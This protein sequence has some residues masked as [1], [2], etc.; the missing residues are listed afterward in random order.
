MRS[1]W[2]RKIEGSNPSTQ[3]YNIY[4]IIMYQLDLMIAAGEVYMIWVIFVLVLV[5]LLNWLNVVVRLSLLSLVMELFLQVEGFCIKGGVVGNYH[6]LFDRF[7]NL[8]VILILTVLMFIFAVSF[9]YMK[10]EGIKMYEIILLMLVGTV[11][12]LGVLRSYN[13]IILFLCLE[14]YSLCMYVIANI[15][16]VSNF[17]TEAGLKYYILGALSSGFFLYGMSICYSVVGSVGYQD[18][19]L[20][21]ACDMGNLLY[22]GIFFIS[23]SFLLK[24]GLA[25]FHVWV[26]DVYEGVTT[27]VS[28]FFSLVPKVGLLSG[29]V[30]L[31][32]GIF[33]NIHPVC[34]EFIGFIGVSSMLFGTMGALWQSKIKRLLAYS[35][36]VNM[37]YLM[38]PLIILTYSGV[39]SFFLYLIIYEYTLLNIFCI[40]LG[41]RGYI[42][43]RV[44]KLIVGLGYLLKNR[45]LVCVC[46]LVSVLSLGGIPPMA[47]FYGKLGL[48]FALLDVQGY[49]ACLFVILFSIVSSIY[50]LRIIRIVFFTRGR[51]GNLRGY[52][53]SQGLVIS[54]LTHCMVFINIYSVSLIL[55]CYGETFSVLF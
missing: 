53:V 25:P 43:G 29:F 22:V 34:Y 30:K 45:Y 50:Y 4:Y 36:I 54:I 47:G 16:R 6:W 14:C 1:A 3:S 27:F 31:I 51:W 10:Y 55:A 11:A 33:Y 18:Y 41:L 15:G 42:L 35:S 2:N 28:M 19:S 8:L 44:V 40:V 26:P 32:W 17:G 39:V 37:G 48:L 9:S 21:L 24:M 38:M 12:L 49:L 7:D 23:S 52:S 20:F 5:G 46:L 13:F